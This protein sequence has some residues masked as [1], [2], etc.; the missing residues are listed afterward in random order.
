M[1]Y[2]RLL[3]D[4][5]YPLAGNGPF[6]RF[7]FGTPTREISRVGVGVGFHPDPNLVFKVEYTFEDGDLIT[8]ASRGDQDQFSAQAAVRF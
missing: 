3:T 1:R 8:G 5:G 6:G 7:V 2:S 4:A